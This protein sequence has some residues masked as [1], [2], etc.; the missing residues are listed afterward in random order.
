MLAA[1][2]AEQR[3]A[4]RPSPSP[5]PSPAPALPAEETEASRSPAGNEADSEAVAPKA[6]DDAKPAAALDEPQLPANMYRIQQAPPAGEA[7]AASPPP[8]ATA[9]A[10]DKKRVSSNASNRDDVRDELL[11]G[12]LGS[13]R[14]NAPAKSALGASAG[15]GSTS[16]AGLGALRPRQGMAAARAPARKPAAMMAQPAAPVV[17]APQ[18]LPE[19]NTERYAHAADNTF[20]HVADAPLSTFS[21]DVDTASYSNVRRFLRDGQRPPTDAVRIEELVNYFHYDYPAPQGDDPVAVSTEISTAPWNE[22]HRLVRIGL[23]ARSLDVQQAPASNLVFLIDV[24]GSMEDPD[25]LPLLQHGLSLLAA[26][27]RPQD[28]VALVVYAGASGLVL[29]STSG[30]NRAE[31]FDA[32]QRLQAGGSTNGG[33]GIRLAYEVARNSFVKGGVNRVILAT[34]GDFNVGTTSEGELVRLIEKERK[35]GIFLTVLGFGRGNVNDSG[36]EALADHGNG[37]YAYIDS[38]AEAHKVL[39][40]EAGSTLVT[41]AKDVKLQIEWNPTRVQ[42]YRLIGFE[43]RMLAARDFNDD[44]KDAGEMGAGHTVTALYEVVPLV[45]NDGSAGAPATVD[46]L[47][48]QHER[49]PSVAAASDEL[50]TIKIRYKRPDAD[51][52]R[53]FSRAVRDESTAFSATSDDFRWATAVAGFGMLLRDSE[54][55]GNATLAM[56]QAIAHDAVGSDPSGERHELIGMMKQAGSLGV[57]KG[58]A[59]AQLAAQR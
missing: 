3:I 36:M 4:T 31:L 1:C 12:A 48:Y 43:N 35:S 27:L 28:H 5:A 22:A 59:S 32:I 33:E 16:G 20:E 47:R 39:V 30:T 54:H 45:A 37:N 52:S 24:S 19:G 50:L 11:Q 17:A 8:P 23:R 56:V 18:A 58:K 51:D 49:A 13:G 14:A 15:V 41:V 26:R 55:K 6:K 9:P 44:A 40:R 25:K 10:E 38:I 42:S 57:G 34:D 29:P 46:P 2:A 7:P 53:L 21:I